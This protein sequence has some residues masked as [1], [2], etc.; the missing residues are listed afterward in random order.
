MSRLEIL[1]EKTDAAGT[2]SRSNDATIPEEDLLPLV[3]GDGRL[4][5]IGVN[6]H[7]RHGPEEGVT[8]LA[9]S[10]AGC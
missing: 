3:H 10:A 6:R 5:R 4:D 9:S 8:C 7:H 2:P 1:G